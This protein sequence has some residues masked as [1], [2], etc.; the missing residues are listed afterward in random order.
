MQELRQSTSITA[1]IGPFV[2]PATGLPVT[3]ADVDQADVQLDKNGAGFGQQNNATSN[4]AHDKGGIYTVTLDA[5]DTNT[6]GR[7]TV[8]VNLSADANTPMVVRHDFMVLD[9]VAYDL[10]YV[11]GQTTAMLG[12]TVVKGTMA[13]PGG[14]STTQGDFASGDGAKAKVG[15]Y[16]WVPATY[17]VRRIKTLSSDSW[18]VDSGDAF[19][20]DPAG[21]TYYI[22][23]VP[24]NLPFV[25]GDFGDGSLT[26][27]KFQTTPASI[28]ARVPIAPINVII[29]AGAHTTTRIIASDATG[30][31]NDRLNGRPMYFLTGTLAKQLVKITDYVS[32]TGQIDFETVD[33]AAVPAAPAQNDTAVIL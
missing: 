8:M 31:L 9:P 10:K 15:F 16:I 27:V 22:L 4:A 18:T 21:A 33:G 29:G 28:L 11:A 2:D 20:T 17:N 26:D 12:F 30:Y 14:H 7:L 19:S 23:A 3:G 5:T 1:K 6:L 13:S 32:T 25:A 24:I